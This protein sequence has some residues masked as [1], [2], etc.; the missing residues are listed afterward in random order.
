MTRVLRSAWF[1][2]ALAL[3]ATAALAG[4]P[5]AV[6]GVA[7]DETAADAAAARDAALAAGQ[8]AAW[9]TLVERLVAP[10]QTAS[11]LALDDARVGT[12]VQSFEV[13]DEKVGPDRYIAHL[14]FNFNETLVRQTFRDL[15]ASRTVETSPP[16]LVLPVL[17]QGGARLLF[18]LENGWNDAWQRVAAGSGLVPV[19]VPIGDLQDIAAIDADRA[20]A[21]DADALA[22]LA[23]RYGTGTVVVVEAH[24][25]ADGT[26]PT[27]LVVDM[28]THRGVTVET[29]S[30]T[31]GSPEAGES[32]VEALYASAAQGVVD[33]LKA[34]WRAGNIVDT[35]VEAVMR[36]EVPVGA[37]GDWIDV[38]RR[39]AGVGTIRRTDIAAMSA[40]AVSL[41]VYYVGDE[42]RLGAALG[43]AGLA[44]QREADVWVLRRTGATPATVIVE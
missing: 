15:G 42:A 12:L 34:A 39:M 44:L 3:T 16:V 14:T 17:E 35:G 33:R 31:F 27:T 18:E 41:V 2:L 7:V 19:V 26:V 37:V 8:R 22:K 36:L 25:P 40:K 5:Y 43:A 9:R 1:V 20:V 10:D 38:T 4:G 6:V 13:I 32:T 24:G 29:G 28:T 11:L 30:A 21:G 23:G